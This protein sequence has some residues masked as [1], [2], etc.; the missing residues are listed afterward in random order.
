M[1]NL[2]C[3]RRGNRGVR[4]R[5]ISV[6]EQRASTQAA[7]Q[8]QAANLQNQAAAAYASG[9]SATGDK[10]AALA[11]QQVELSDQAGAG[12]WRS[13]NWPWVAVG[14][15]AVALTLFLED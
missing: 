13:K 10:L 15:G 9:D 14:G 6:L 8:Q 4:R 12:D 3:F 7:A 11:Q 1:S 5:Y 2:R